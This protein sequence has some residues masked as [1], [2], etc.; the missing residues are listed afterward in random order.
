MTKYT[1]TPAH[2]GTNEKEIQKAK[3]FFRDQVKK[4][5][6]NTIT[7]TINIRFE[8]INYTITAS[9]YNEAGQ[10]VCKACKIN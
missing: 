4:E 9:Y 10:E 7:D 5:T 8:D 2:S 3:R 1:I 6:Y